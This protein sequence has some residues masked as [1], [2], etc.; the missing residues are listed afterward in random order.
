M[1]HLCTYFLSDVFRGYSNRTLS[2]NGF[3]IKA[4][5][6]GHLTLPFWLYRKTSQTCLKFTICK[7]SV[8]KKYITDVIWMSLLI[9]LNKYSMISDLV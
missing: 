1:F 8:N 7:Q 9:I 5:E 3:I 6:Q 4:S 2:L